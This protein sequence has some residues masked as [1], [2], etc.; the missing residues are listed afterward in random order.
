MV[1]VKVFS[2]RGVDKDD[3][4]K[5]IED[6]E[7]AALEKDYQDEIAMV[8]ME[9]DQ[10][11]KNLLFGKTLLADLIDPTSKERLSKKGD[12]IDRAGHGRTCP[13]TS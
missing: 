1:D 9:R 3:R 2:R 5:S 10:K 4:A 11:L 12:K 6:E 7:I 13:G 8:E